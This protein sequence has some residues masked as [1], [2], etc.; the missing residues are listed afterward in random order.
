L[1]DPGRPYEPVTVGPRRSP[2]IKNARTGTVLVSHLSRPESQPSASRQGILAWE[3]EQ[4]L[5]FT[6]D[7][8]RTELIVVRLA[9]LS[10]KQT[11]PDDSSAHAM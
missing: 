11:E 7:P 1:D 6:V 4:T 2:G 5:S 8:G 3:I 9:L 10:E